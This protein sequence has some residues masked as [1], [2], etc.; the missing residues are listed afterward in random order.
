MYQKKF[1]SEILRAILFI[2]AFCFGSFF[3]FVP[4]ALAVGNIDSTNKYAWSENVGWID[5]GVAGGAVAVSDSSLTGYAY[6]E[7]IG[8]VSLNCSNTSSCATYDYGVVNDGTGVLS[9]YAWSENTGWINFKPAQGGVTISSS[10]VFSGYAYGENIGWINFT[11]DNPVTTSWRASSGSPAP[12]S[13]QSSVTVYHGNGPIA[14][15]NFIKD[16]RTNNPMS[17]EYKKMM[18]ASLNNVPQ[19]ISTTTVVKSN[20]ATAVHEIKGDLFFGARNNDVIEL[21]K[22]LN[23]TASPVALVGPGSKGNETSYFGVAT[24]SAL[25]KWQKANNIS[26]AVGYFGAKTKAKIRILGDLT[27]QSI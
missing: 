25:S 2:T 23:T 27:M 20:L 12:S 22:F 19:V 9:G 1:W 21:Q 8:W 14:D 6:C 24:K 3:V 10:G 26:P 7:N 11:V 18:K 13:S 17:E 5:F 16:L 4:D 15:E